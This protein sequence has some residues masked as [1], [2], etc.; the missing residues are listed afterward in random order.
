[1][2]LFY[3]RAVFIIFIACAVSNNRSETLQQQQKGHGSRG[4]SAMTNDHKQFKSHFPFSKLLNQIFFAPQSF[5]VLSI[6]MANK[7][8]DSILGGGFQNVKVVL[9]TVY[10]IVL[11]LPVLILSPLAY[12][13]IWFRVNI[14]FPLLRLTIASSG[15]VS[16]Q[17]ALYSV[18]FA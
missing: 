9:R 16:N 18:C 2:P 17:I 8:E 14:W 11:F 1:M 6:A 4:N 3:C 5:S 12:V 15:A 10:L 7:S 13:S